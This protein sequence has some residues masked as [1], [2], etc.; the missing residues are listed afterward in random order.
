MV[1]ESLAPKLGNCGA[2]DSAHNLPSI[3]HATPELG[4]L[5]SGYQ[6]LRP[7][8]IKD[9]VCL[10]QDRR[11]SPAADLA[12]REAR[13]RYRAST[14]LS[15]LNILCGEA[16]VRLADA[17]GT[18]LDVIASYGSPDASLEPLKCVP[19]A[20][21]VWLEKVESWPP[22]GTVTTW[23]MSRG[24]RPPRL[25]RPGLVGSAHSLPGSLV[26]LTPSR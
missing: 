16:A 6:Q 17:W 4:G 7:E 21:N 24:P 19:G 8:P 18:N 2:G 10:P 5:V 25:P 15:A 26:L 22:Q 3:L 9:A 1:A 14:E 23:D 20:S 13:A 12:A 11:S